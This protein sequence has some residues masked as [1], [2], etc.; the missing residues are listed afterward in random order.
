MDSKAKKVA[1]F[2]SRDK[3]PDDSFTENMLQ[4]YE[5][6]RFARCESDPHIHAFSMYEKD[7]GKEIIEALILAEADPLDVQMIFEIPQEVFAI[8]KDLFFDMANFRSRLDKILYVETY[9]GKFGKEIKLRALHLGADFIFFKYGNYI[10]KT[11]SQRVMVKRMFMA[12][13]YRAMEANFNPIDSRIT[14]ASTEHAKIMLRAYEC[15]EKLMAEDTGEGEN[16]AKVLTRREMD[17]ARINNLQL[18]P[19][20]II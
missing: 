9:E 15:I 14:K 18:G 5:H 7:L 17:V 12:A 2:I 13:S 4:Y 1:D 11:E 20:D 19:G 10:P 6:K 8:Y 16:M 3:E